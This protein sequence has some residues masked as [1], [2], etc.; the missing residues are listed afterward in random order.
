M[1]YALHIE[2]SVQVL[3]LMAEAAG[4]QL[5][6]LGLEPFA[7]AVLGPDTDKIGPRNHPPLA[8]NAEASQ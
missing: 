6:P 3:Q 5:L 7:I 2:V 4:H 8:R 1:V